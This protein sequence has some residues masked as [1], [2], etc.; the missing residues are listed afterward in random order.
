MI[1]KKTFIDRIQ[2]KVNENG[3]EYSKKVCTDIYEALVATVQD[4]LTEGDS[5]RLDGVGTFDIMFRS[6][7]A[8]TSALNGKQWTSP[9][10]IV[11]H[12][13]FSENLKNAVAATYNEKKHKPKK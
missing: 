11:P 4:I 1:N 7:R 9:D 10:T 12:I 8:G 3:S 2:A 13:K 5:V 6:G